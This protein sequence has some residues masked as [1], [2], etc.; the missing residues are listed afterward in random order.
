VVWLIAT[1]AIAFGIVL[2]ILA[3][4]ARGFAKRLRP[5]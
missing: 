2:I 4:K 5:A 1:Y 3:F